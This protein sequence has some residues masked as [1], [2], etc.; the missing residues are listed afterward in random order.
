MHILS[1]TQ[2]PRKVIRLLL[3]YQLTIS[4]P[5]LVSHSIGVKSPLTEYACA[6]PKQI[7]LPTFFSSKDRELLA[8]TAL[9]DALNQKLVSLNSEFDSLRLYTSSIDWCQKAWWDTDT[10]K[11]TFEDWCLADA[12]YRSRALELPSRIGD[13]MVPILDMANHSDNDEYNARFDVDENDRVLLVLR[14]GKT[15]EE[16]GEITISYG[17]GGASEMIFSYGF[18]EDGMSDA[19]EMYLT[20]RIADDDPLRMAKMHL[21]GEAPG[22]RLFRAADGQVSWESNFIWWM[23][24]NQ[25][26]GLDFELAQTVE[27]QTELQA[28]W[29]GKSLDPDNLEATMRQDNRWDIFLLRAT[30]ALQERME[31]QG[32]KL[33]ISQEDFEETASYISA[34]KQYTYDT[35]RTLRKLELDLLTASYTTLENKVRPK[36]LQ[37]LSSAVI[38]VVYVDQGL[39][40]GVE[41]GTN[42]ISDRDRVPCST[43]RW[44]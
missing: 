29:K 40:I 37:P 34:D 38:V 30:V 2:S 41:T 26:D 1:E 20:L 8:G 33:S 9:E 25:E 42:D 14:D 24:I 4:S 32:E 27:G 28:Q 6:L 11:L 19:R 35:I 3:L 36:S 15:V 16:R 18:L 12:M 22:V 21:C 39:T 23:C 10:G 13:A 44:P 43:S 5:D 17:C 7:P 31:S